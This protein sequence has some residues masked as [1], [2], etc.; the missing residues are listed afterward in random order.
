MQFDAIVILMMCYG[1]ITIGTTSL[2]FWAFRGGFSPAARLFLFSELFRIPVII[3]VGAANAFPEYRISAVFL[4]SHAA[5]LAS[6][7][8]FVFSLYVLKR[9]GKTD[10]FY[11][12][13]GFLMILS[14]LV[15]ILRLNN[16]SIP[17]LLSPIIFACL[18]SAA[19]FLCQP[20]GQQ[21]SVITPFWR[22]LQLLELSFFLI[23]LS[24]IAFYI[25]GTALSPL[26][27]GRDNAILLAVL[28]SVL[29]FR[30]LC[31]QSIWMTWI[32]PD[33]AE[34]RFNRNLLKS[35]QDREVLL[36]KLLASN[37]RLGMNALASLLA[38]ELSQPLTGAVLQTEALKRDLADSGI[39]P[40]NAAAL[41]KISLQ[42]K[43]LSD[44]VQN[45]RRFF[46]ENMQ[47]RKPINL[48]QICNELLDLV[49]ASNAAGTSLKRLYH[50]NPVVFGDDI[51]LQQ[52]IKNIIN[53][54]IDALQG[55]DAPDKTITITIGQMEHSAII[56]IADN[57]K[58]IDPA[59][60]PHLF[61]L[62]RTTKDTGVG[63]G[64]WLCKEIVE[65]HKGR[66]SAAA[67]E[68]GRGAV[69]TIE[70]PLAESP[71]R[72]NRTSR[73]SERS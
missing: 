29:V 9:G 22:I 65:R 41:D 30:F 19:V 5:F 26:E 56:S 38:H 44:L 21:N 57:G 33:T 48:A 49:E 61:D 28:V 72:T 7:A 45:L 11:V 42:L 36:R 3:S 37:R 4:I 64:L 16:P 66:I 62:Y 69:I 10:R 12:A 13:I 14:V 17:A 55:T 73:A 2:L 63:V 70:L 23:S 35:L 24:R 60:L 47:S 1:L 25:E 6:E 46:S 52:V 54:A 32:A 40:S 68:A 27:G 43:K 58:G 34:N 53:N 8:A 59:V 31:Y 71:Q 20:T 39:S 18:S 67:N 51:Q 50:S 15:E